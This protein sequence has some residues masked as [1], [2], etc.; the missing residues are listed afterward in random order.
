M[1]K[2]QHYTTMNQSARTSESFYHQTW[3]NVPENGGGVETK[4]MFPSRWTAALL[5]SDNR[6]TPRR[7][8]CEVRPAFRGLKLALL[9]CKVPQ[10]KYWLN[11][12][13]PPVV[14]MLNIIS[15]AI[16]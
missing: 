16:E 10:Q 12:V 8:R 9:I 7:S 13:A 4:I 2:Q 15:F 1:S 11:M 5:W 3:W 6:T 14:N